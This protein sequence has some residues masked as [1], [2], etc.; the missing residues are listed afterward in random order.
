MWY[1][2]LG[3]RASL[4][5]NSNG[6]IVT[7]TI[8][9]E[10]EVHQLRGTLAENAR[11]FVADNSQHGCKIYGYVGFNYAAHIR[12]QTYT[13]GQWPLLCLTEPR[14]EITL[15]RKHVTVTGSEPERKLAMCDVLN[16]LNLVSH[17][18]SPHFVHVDTATNAVDYTTRVTEA[19][20]EIAEHQVRILGFFSSC[21]RLFENRQ[22]ECE[23]GIIFAQIL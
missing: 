10:R 3:E 8:E 5:V 21:S 18:D 4:S 1:L 7:T 2:G 20:A 16:C 14:V 22:I 6:K 12:H 11:D 19:L 17:F 15:D 13:P 9:G 23:S